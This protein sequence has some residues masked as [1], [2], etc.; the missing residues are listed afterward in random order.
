MTPTYRILSLVLMLFLLIRSAFATE[1]AL[2][3]VTLQL[4]W[5]HQFQ[6]AGYYA[7]LDKGYYRAAGLEVRIVEP[8]A[9][10]KSVE[11]VLKG[12]AEFGV[13]NSDL[14]LYRQLGEPVV[15]LGVIF[16]HSPMAILARADRV[17]NLHDLAGRV[18]MLEP[19][20]AELHAY[21]KRENMDL[22][23]IHTRPHSYDVQALI[24]G[25]VDAL[26]AYT[27]DEP[28]A[29][30][31]A[32]V[33]VL[34]FLPLSGGID[35]YGDNL[36]TTEQQQRDHPQR[37]AAFRAAS[38]KGWAYAMQHPEEIIDL[39]LEK[40]SNRHS[41]EHLLFEARQMRRLIAP[42]QVAIGY[43]NPGRWQ[44]IADTYAELGLLPRSISL[45]G[46][47]YEPHEPVDLERFYPY[48]VATLVLLLA[49]V[50]TT[51]FVLRLNR[52]LMGSERRY[53]TVY[54]N[55]PLAFVLWGQDGRI[56][57]WNRASE[58]IF[59][60]SL[61]EVQGRQV[62]D[63][64]VP[65][66][67]QSQVQAEI[68]SAINGAGPSRSLHWN[69][70]KSGEQVLCEWIHTALCDEKGCMTVV[71]LALDV[72]ARV[73][74]EERLREAL[75]SQQAIFDCSNA[76]ICVVDQEL[77]FVEVNNHLCRLLGYGR[78]E[79]IGHSSALLHP[80]E[81]AYRRF[82]REI[83]PKVLE[84]SI[85]SLEYR[86]RHRDG[87]LVWCQI[88]LGVIAN[89]DPS[90]GLVM[91][92]VEIGERKRV[93]QELLAAREA[94]EQANRSKSAFLANMSHELRT[95]LHAILGFTQ[96]LQQEF[97]EPA[98]SKLDIIA[99]SGR[100]LLSL[101]DEVL[102][103]A[104]VESGRMELVTE[105]FNPG[106][107]LEELAQTYQLRCRE[108]GLEFRY[109]GGEDLPAQLEGDS[110]KLRQIL[111]NLLGNALRFT[112]QGWVELAAEYREQTLAL[113]VSD[114]GIGFD[115]QQRG[116][117]FEPF[118]QLG[119]ERQSAGGTGLGLA[120]ASRLLEL[121]EGSLRVESE[122]GRG[123]QFRL[124]LPARIAVAGREVT[125]PPRRARV[126]GYRRKE[127]SG[128]LRLLIVDD[129]YTN[130]DIL[131]YMLAPLGFD[132]EEAEDGRQALE[133][134][135]QKRPDLVL[136]DI[137][138]EGLDGLEVARRLRNKEAGE[139]LPI[140]AVSAASFR[141]DREAALAA[142]C[143]A[144]MSKPVELEALLEVLA[145]QLPLVWCRE[146][147]HPQSSPP[148]SEGND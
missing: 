128:P 81:Q 23:R 78:E 5:K 40:Y 95:P 75:R 88:N 18:L 126:T 59:G 2:D 32:G 55:A 53:R 98:L 1:G 91:V 117:I 56:T 58:R 43:M 20:A 137:R 124:E 114:S 17:E 85:N 146:G 54:E 8:E 130:R 68:T 9:G 15:V 118:V 39:I 145:S 93:E 12:A 120:I 62:L 4:K 67:E 79:L 25:E 142:G 106:L 129:D 30:R 89:D 125:E 133:R 19:D 80:D 50:A 102:D 45:Q 61:E 26:S 103:L 27:T 29:V 31:Q 44:H 96:V 86:L 22:Q 148:V 48:I 51:L 71:A 116:R 42:E 47:L 52:R 72:T 64:M 134:V 82:T 63:F 83:Y 99:N 70:T 76:G 104:K 90:S 115:P 119:D 6:F 135:E 24:S 69:L 7:A 113:T 38:L 121:M 107:L 100:H 10:Q 41:R 94:A 132:L 136:L 66:S 110:R 16:Q 123:S 108:K 34:E 35:F 87:G 74:A 84:G 111:I 46:F 60:W 37:V 36:F 140:V 139:C 101:I 73:R 77:S 127:G 109:R 14:L 13:G 57:G 21:L 112:E 3:S 92:V 147:E 49:A 105:P 144:H 97:P 143:V 28:F 138:M 131:R 141:E 122:P 65:L 11:Q 33:Q